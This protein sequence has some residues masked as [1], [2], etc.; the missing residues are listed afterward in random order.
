MKTNLI[1]PVVTFVANAHKSTWSHVRIANDTFPVAFFA[2]ATDGNSWLL[3]AH[4]QIR[5]MLRHNAAPLFTQLLKN[6]VQNFLLKQNGIGARKY[7]LE[8][9]TQTINWAGTTTRQNW[10]L[11]NK[12]W[13]DRNYTVLCSPSSQVYKVSYFGSWPRSCNRQWGFRFFRAPKG[14]AG[15]TDCSRVEGSRRWRCF[16]RDFV[17]R[18]EVQPIPYKT[19]FG[20]LVGGR[21]GISIHYRRCGYDKRSDWKIWRQ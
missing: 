3:P 16:V 5:M 17:L 4:D 8:D 7:I 18:T 14:F 21:R 13:L 9:K 15:C 2:Q 12:C 6:T 19:I 10:L 20:A 1:R 11:Q